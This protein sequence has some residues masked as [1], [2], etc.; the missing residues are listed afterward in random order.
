MTDGERDLVVAQMAKARK[1]I[2]VARTLVSAGHHDDAISRA[3]YAAFHAASA[4]LLSEGIT[5]ES[6]QALKTMFGLRFVKTGKIGREYGRWLTDLKDDRENGDYDI[7]T[8]FDEGDAEDAIAKAEAGDG[9]SHS[10]RYASTS[11]C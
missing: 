8:D 1:K 7:Y 4:V 10:R 5:V 11:D 9:R 6:H 2:S 3:Y